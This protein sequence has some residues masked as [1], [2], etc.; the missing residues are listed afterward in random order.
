MKLLSSAAV[1]AICFSLAVSSAFAQERVHALSGT[2]TTIHP[3]IQMT[4]IN[5]DDGSSGHFE[6]LSKSNVPVDFN[7]NVSADATP[8]DKFATIGT[9]AIVYYIGDGDVRTIV[10]LHDIGTGPLVNSVGTIVKWDKHGGL[11]TIKNTKGGEESFQVNAKTVADMPTGVAEDF[12]FDL[13]KKDKV[14]V[15]ATQASG[16]QTALLITPA[17]L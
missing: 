5:T 15:I 9:H 14:R 3:K 7:K 6:W 10:A 8:A 2:V 1:L 11:L 16:S 17:T 12:K 13:D 4:E